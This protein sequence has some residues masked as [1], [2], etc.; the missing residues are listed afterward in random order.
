ML[1]D[2]TWEV[3]PREINPQKDI[4]FYGFVKNAGGVY[5]FTH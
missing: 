5:I 2:R 4:I 3:L 1:L